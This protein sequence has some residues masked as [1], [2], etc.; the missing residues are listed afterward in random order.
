MVGFDQSDI[1]A[2]S[3]SER[4]VVRVQALQVAD[5]GE[6]PYFGAVAGTPGSSYL[7]LVPDVPGHH[8]DSDGELESVNMPVPVL[9]RGMVEWISLE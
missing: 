1:V 3:A 8:G 7:A 5:W 4:A 2:S 6:I 9:P